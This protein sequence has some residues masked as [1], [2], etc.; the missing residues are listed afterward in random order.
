VRILNNL[1]PFEHPERA[2]QEGTISFVRPG[3]RSMYKVRF[4]DGREYTFYGDQLEAIYNYGGEIPAAAAP[5]AGGGR[6]GKK[7]KRFK[8]PRGHGRGR[9][10]RV[11]TRRH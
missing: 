5:A 4:D 3:P 8:A 6:R 1:G 9:R 7:T 11:Q 10:R 2:G